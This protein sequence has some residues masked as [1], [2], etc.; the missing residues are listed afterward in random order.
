MFRVGQ[1]ITPTKLIRNF[2]RI[3]NHIVSYPQAVLITHRNGKHL[4]LMDAQLFDRMMER[5]TIDK[6]ALPPETGLEY[7]LESVL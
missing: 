2:S 3:A 4:V 5:A 6:A 7:E 1:I